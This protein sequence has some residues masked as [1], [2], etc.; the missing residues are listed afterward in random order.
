MGTRD[1]NLAD[2]FPL[3]SSNLNLIGRLL[4]FLRKKVFN[5]GFY[6]AKEELG[7]VIRRFFN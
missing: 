7:N 3:Y 4:K 5:I 1:E 6:R 2:F